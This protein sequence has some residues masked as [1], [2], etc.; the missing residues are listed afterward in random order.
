MINHVKFVIWHGFQENAGET[1]E[2]LTLCLEVLSFFAKP[3]WNQRK[4]LDTVTI[5]L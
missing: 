1:H 5:W 3:K 4:L 2:V